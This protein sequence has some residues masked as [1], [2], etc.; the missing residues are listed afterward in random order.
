MK[1]ERCSGP[2]L[3]RPFINH[4]KAFD[5]YPEDNRALGRQFKK[6]RSDR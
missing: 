5:L 4:A 1:S 6:P 3:G 2:R